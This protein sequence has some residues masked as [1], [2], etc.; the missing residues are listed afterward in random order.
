MPAANSLPPDPHL[1]LCHPQS[2]IS[3]SPTLSDETRRRLG[4]GLS[5]APVHRNRRRRDYSWPLASLLIGSAALALLF[6]LARI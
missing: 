2:S 5:A 3:M 1:S 4:L 6:A